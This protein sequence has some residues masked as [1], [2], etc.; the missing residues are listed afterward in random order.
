MFVVMQHKAS[1]NTKEL[2]DALLKKFIVA[3]GVGKVQQL[4]K[5]APND[6]GSDFFTR[7]S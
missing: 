6:T 5:M 1:K 4:E 2:Y 7:I 3:N